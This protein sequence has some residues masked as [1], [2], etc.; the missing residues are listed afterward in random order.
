VSHAPDVLVGGDDAMERA[1]SWR[2]GRVPLIVAL[3]AAITVI[4]V[5]KLADQSG[6]AP[7]ASASPDPSAFFGYVA[8]G[9]STLV[10][11][12]DGE[13]DVSVTWDLTGSEGLTVTAVS[14]R[15]Q[16]LLATLQSLR[17]SRASR[18]GKVSLLVTPACPVAQSQLAGALLV[19]TAEAHG[20]TKQLAVD[21]GHDDAFV[22]AV[23]GVC[24]RN[25]EHGN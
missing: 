8:L 16:G 13:P 23:T 18:T 7:S 5:L 10:Q 3:L 22:S 4:A 6:R 19:A 1:P 24:E 11:A 2:R 21:V 25:R 15:G 9:H 20:K 17:W 12:V 14:I